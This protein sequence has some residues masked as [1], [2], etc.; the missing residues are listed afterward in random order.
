MSCFAVAHS[1]LLSD[2]IAAAFCAHFSKRV[3][4]QC[5]G[6]A[7]FE[8][9]FGKLVGFSAGRRGVIHLVAGI[10]NC[11]AVALALSLEDFRKALGSYP[12]R[13]VFLAAPVVLIFDQF[14]LCQVR[15]DFV[16]VHQ[17]AGDVVG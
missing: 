11:H 4:L 13:V 3:R 10:A 7:R 8:E 12:I 1:S 6:L 15:N 16:D 5:F 2:V 17:N 9:S 14:I